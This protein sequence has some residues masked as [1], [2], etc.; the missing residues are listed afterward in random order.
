MKHLVKHSWAA[1]RILFKNC[2]PSQAA[3]FLD[4][5]RIWPAGRSFHTPELEYQ[6]TDQTAEWY[7]TSATGS[8]DLGFDSKSGQTN[9]FKLGVH[10]FP[11]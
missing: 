5:N 4:A 9:D 11:A 3:R 10:S 2:N 6:I 1:G 8:A 7:R